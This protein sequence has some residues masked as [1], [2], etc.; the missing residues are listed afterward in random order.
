MTLIVSWIDKK[1]AHQCADSRLISEGKR[2]DD[3]NKLISLFEGQI[4]IGIAGSWGVNG[5]PIPTYINNLMPHFSEVEI[6]EKNSFIRYFPIFLAARLRAGMHESEIKSEGVRITIIT[7]IDSEFI[8]SGIDSEFVNSENPS[9]YG[10]KYKVTANEMYRGIGAKVIVRGNVIVEEAFNQA[11][12]ISQGVTNSDILRGLIKEKKYDDI[13]GGR[14]FNHHY[15]FETEKIVNEIC[16]L[17]RLEEFRPEVIHLINELTKK[18]FD[19]KISNV[20]VKQHGSETS[21]NW[22]NRQLKLNMNTES[23]GLDLF[24]DLLHEYGHFIDGI[25][26]KEEEKSLKREVSAWLNAYDKFNELGLQKHRESFIRRWNQ[27]I[28][29]YYLH[30]AENKSDFTKRKNH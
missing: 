8:I 22:D 2:Y 7:Y 27:C 10:P 25:P 29:T 3:N 20:P 12:E 15:V 9:L 13:I 11:A 28:E 30:N 23:K 26:E 1:G 21:I 17:G 18:C 4:L 14:V 19:I 24:W 6:E 16:D 5:E